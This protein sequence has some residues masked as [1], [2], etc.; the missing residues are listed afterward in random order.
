MLGWIVSSKID[1]IEL[2]AA[3]T[4][5]GRRQQQFWTTCFALVIYRLL[6]Y[7]SSFF[8]RL[9]SF[10]SLSLSLAYHVWHKFGPNR[11]WLIRAERCYGRRKL[12]A[13]PAGIFLCHCLRCEFGQIL[14]FI[15]KQANASYSCK[16]QE[17]RVYFSCE[18]REEDGHF[19]VVDDDDG[20]IDAS[21]I[22]FLLWMQ[23]IKNFL[24]RVGSLVCVQYIYVCIVYLGWLLLLIWE[25]DAALGYFP[26]GKKRWLQWEWSTEGRKEEKRGTGHKIA[27]SQPS[28]V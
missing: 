26:R 7:A 5:L 25:F 8:L 23:K 19:T 20:G 12:T 2:L 4:S 13:L 28:Q 18:E 1:E 9:W 27:I 14:E 22:I 10:L 17:M 11:L 15:S 21:I 3:F 24:M 16:W 6:C